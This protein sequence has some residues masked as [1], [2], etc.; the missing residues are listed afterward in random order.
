MAGGGGFTT[1]CGNPAPGPGR[2]RRLV[3]AGVWR[4]AGGRGEHSLS[5]MFKG[6]GAGGHARWWRWLW[7]LR[8][9]GAWRPG[10]TGEAVMDDVQRPERRPER[11]LDWRLERRLEQRLERRLERRP[12]RHPERRLE[13][14]LE[15]RFELL[16][17]Q[18]LAR[19]P[20]GGRR[21]P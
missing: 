10:L 17:E 15:R 5:L 3:D 11:H 6:A 7:L 12:E 1:A 2:C 19:L 4:K 20:G 14:L 18:R 21:R 9:G 16:T 8:I 13:R